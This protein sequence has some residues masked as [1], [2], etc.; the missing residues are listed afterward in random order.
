[1]EFTAT[2]RFA[3]VLVF[4]ATL[5]LPGTVPAADVATPPLD[6]CVIAFLPHK[7][8]EPI[9]REISRAQD[10]AREDA[11]SIVWLERLGWLFTAKARH[12]YDPGYWKLA[13]QCGRCIAARRPHS[14]EALLLLGHVL[15]SLHRFHEAETMAR[16]LIAARGLH[17]DW[18][19]LGD[20]LMEQGRLAEAIDAYQKMIDLKPGP[21]SYSRAAHVR[22]LKGDL[23]GAI[24]LARMAAR[25]SDPRDPDS[26]AWSYSRLALYELQAGDAKQALETCE[27]ALQ[28]RPDHAETLL[29]RGRILLAGGNA[30]E[31]IRALRGAAALNPLPEYRWM[32]AEALRE[33]GLEDE[34]IAEE[35]RLVRDGAVSDPRTLALFLATRGRETGAALNLAQS[36][37]KVRADVFTL[38]AL[39]W[40]LHAS[41][42][43]SEAGDV[44]RRALAEGTADARLFYHAGVI[45]A[46]G[47]HRTD[48]QRWLGKA[49]ALRQML[50]PSERAA[51]ARLLV[52]EKTQSSSSTKADIGFRRKTA[53]KEIS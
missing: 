22:W 18:G 47:H 26:S 27:I 8:T 49:D 45:A 4:A 21:Q 3:F 23:R 33:G 53:G 6:P 24:E 44:M 20:A 13:E 30:S 52:T 41:G 16:E 31:A 42:R 10:R 51:L 50:L 37:L 40:A 1:M 34:A 11:A 19:L 15:D 46:A 7:G 2:G 28:I 36:E 38:D 39:A 17:F 14:P 5:V 43:A 12:S 29:V 25:A 35:V 48:A 32:L 9:D